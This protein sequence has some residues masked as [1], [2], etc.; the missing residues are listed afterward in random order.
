MGN[1]R[2]IERLGLLCGLLVFAATAW[3]DHPSR[4][5]P[6][7]QTPAQ[8]QARQLS[9]LGMKYLLQQDYHQAIK[10]F[11]VAAQLDPEDADTYFNWGYALG[12]LGQRQAEIE[13][14]E[15][16]VRYNPGLGQAY[17]AWAA[18]L[19][20]LGKETEARAKVREA[21][22]I[23]PGMLHPVEVLMLKSLDLMD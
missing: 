13:K 2:M 15:Q 5:R 14:Y 20:Q 23:A 7:P 18:A 9:A 22:T 21:L 19:L 3:G 1:R 17:A 16:A 12:A 4:S 6:A 8:E 10:A 11:Q